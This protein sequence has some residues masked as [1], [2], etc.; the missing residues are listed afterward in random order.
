MKGAIRMAASGQ[1][2]RFETTHLSEG[3]EHII[4]FS[5][6]PVRDSSGDIVL[7]IPE[8]R[9]ITGFKRTEQALRESE[10]R[11]SRLSLAS[12][13]GIAITGEGIVLDANQQL[14]KML[15][16]ELHELMGKS[17]LETGGPGLSGAG[18]G[19]APPG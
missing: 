7:L 2:I 18:A 11:F 8:G 15:G 9:D 19:K 17:V 16:Y 5:L 4:D 10:E 12:F 13:E 6:K 14:A 3:V 1:F